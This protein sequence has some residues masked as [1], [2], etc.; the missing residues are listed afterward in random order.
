[1]DH[2]LI[3]AG[4][5]QY[6]QDGKNEETNPKLFPSMG[7]YGTGTKNRVNPVNIRRMIIRSIFL[8]NLSRVLNSIYSPFT[9]LNRLP[10]EA[11]PSISTSMPLRYP[12]LSSAIIAMAKPSSAGLPILCSQVF[13][14]I[15]LAKSDCCTSCVPISVSIRPGLT[16]TT[17]IPF[18]A[19]S[20]AHYWAYHTTKFLLKV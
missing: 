20:W 6:L 14:I 7:I 4:K 11:P 13:S 5:F 1:M 3:A 16:E 2:C 10:V 12:F 9:F 8:L 19:Y 17:R 18:L 15:C